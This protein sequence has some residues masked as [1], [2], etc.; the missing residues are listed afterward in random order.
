MDAQSATKYEMVAKTFQGLEDVLR[1]ELISLGADNVQIGRRMVSFEG[2]KRMMYRANLCCR[3]ALRILKPIVKFTAANPDELY[4]CV[5][6]IDWSQFMSADSTFAIDSTVN[7]S[8][9][10]HSRFVT[11]RVKDGIADY[12]NDLCGRR[13]SIRLDGADIL[14][15]VHISDDRITISIDSSGEPLSKRGYRV[16]QTA[17]PINE[18]LAAGII[19]KTGWR[20]ESNFVDPMCGSG[21]FLTE[22]ALIASNINPGIYRQEFAFEKWPDFDPELFDELCSDDSEERRFEYKIYG[23]DIDP[24]AVAIARRNIRSAGLEGMI[25]LDCKAFQDWPDAPLPG[26]LITNPPYGERLRGDDLMKLFSEIGTELKQNFK[27]YHAWI[28]AYKKEHF[29]AIGF[30]PS[31]KFPI[32]NGSLECTLREYVIFEGKHED[33]VREGGTIRND[34]FNRE[35]RPRTRHLSDR[36]WESGSRKFNRDT[37]KKMRRDRDEEFGKRDSKRGF[38]KRDDRR[39]NRR[40]D[41]RRDRN[42]KDR[43][44][45]R[46]Q[47]WDREER[48]D[49]RNIR[50]TGRNAGTRRDK[51]ILVEGKG[52]QLPPEA[53]VF[54]AGKE[55]VKMRS[56][57]GWYKNNSETSENTEQD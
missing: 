42:F 13:P 22:A 48:E 49:R 28:L 29:D 55:G 36:E 9:F 33:F 5:R 37:A 1:D 15:N 52:P 50:L 54:R 18:V 8:E 40:R 51:A 35:S 19:L 6:D 10:T 12:F 38:G 16:D 14:F 46:R 2:D 11:Y 53:T 20:G 25:E 41:D 31:V 21:T 27:G 56:R 7:S 44:D 4:D 3:T 30:K 39:D 23:S 45:D 43:R 17:A 24:D 32:L 47:R 57:K 26:I 34:D